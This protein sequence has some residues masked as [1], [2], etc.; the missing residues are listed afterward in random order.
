MARVVQDDFLPEPEGLRDHRHSPVA[1]FLV[2]GVAG[3]FIAGLL[4]SALAQV[5]SVVRAAGRVT[6]AGKVKVVNHARGGRI[7]EIRVEEGQRVGAGQVLIV[8]DA[9]Q[10]QAAWSELRG[11]FEV[12]SAAAARLDAEASGGDLA[13]PS[14][15]ADARPDLVAAEQALLA[16]R[17]EAQASAREALTKAVARADGQL[18]AY[19]AERARLENSAELLAQQA[20]AVR[21]LTRKGLYP[22]LKQVTVERQ[23][24]DAKGELARTIEEITSAEAA[25]AEAESELAG[26]ERSYRARVLGELGQARAERDRLREELRQIESVVAALE[27]RAPVDGIVQEVQVAAPGQSVGANAPLLKLVPIGEG[28]VVEAR[29]ANEDIGD[30][31]LG[32]KAT[33]KVRAFDYLRHG[34][35]TG[36]VVR[37]DSDASVPVEGEPPSYGIRVLTAA[38]AEAT[39]GFEVAPG[40]LV[41]VELKAGERTILSYLTDRIF[42]VKDQAFRDG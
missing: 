30:V 35:L 38:Q 1:A 41:D 8:F 3:L 25:L 21:E 42:A 6:P 23:L 15:L 34:A 9:E 33:I 17:R 4:W 37:I 36:E 11:R 13:I 20:D 12:Q 16:A 29:V 31:K 18:R 32:Q 28:L 40:M 2:L 14:E 22:K 39:D 24:S 10:H 5:D 7:A 27:V 26:L 19:G